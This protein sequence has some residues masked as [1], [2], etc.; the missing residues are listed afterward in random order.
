[1]LKAL[2]GHIILV[3]EF[4]VFSGSYG[5]RSLV[6]NQ[7]GPK[8]AVREPLAENRQPLGVTESAR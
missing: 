3:F 1:M 6:A 5:T 2:A 7:N 8:L 4:A